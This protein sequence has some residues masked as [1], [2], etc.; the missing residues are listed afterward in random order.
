MIEL[1]TLSPTRFSSAMMTQMHN[2]AMI[3][4]TG[5]GAPSTTLI[6]VNQSENGS[7]LCL[8][9]AQLSLP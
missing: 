5:R 8:E 4:L 7:P 1:K 9:S 6:R 3:E 2:E